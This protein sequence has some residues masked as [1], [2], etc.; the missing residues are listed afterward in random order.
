MGVV[1][2][3]I[4]SA[5]ALSL[6]RVFDLDHYYLMTLRLTRPHL[7]KTTRR[8]GGFSLHHAR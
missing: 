5:A 2:E 4:G 8:H 1:A 6:P 3:P 7:P